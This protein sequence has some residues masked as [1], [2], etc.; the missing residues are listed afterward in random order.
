IDG[1]RLL[2]AHA[3][4]PNIPSKDGVTP[5]LMAS[6]SGTH[7]NDDVMAPTGRLAAVKYLVEELH[8]DVNAADIAPPAP[9]TPAAPA[10]GP[11]GAAGAAPPAPAGGATP[12]TNAAQPAQ[13]AAEGAAVPA[14]PAAQQPQQ[15]QQQQQQ[16]GRNRDAGFTP[17]HHAAARGDTTMILYLISK[18]A[19]IGAVTKNGVTV[20]DMA[21]GPRQ[22][23]QPYAETVALLELLGSKNS[24]KC[25]SC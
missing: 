8:A 9:A 6:G 22:R 1:M 19:R 2:V 21:N 10:A 14:Q 25:V 5:L 24:H 7:G 13:P 11:A 4:D 23:I 16:R 15:Q 18:G 20:A 17:L 12:A 3:A